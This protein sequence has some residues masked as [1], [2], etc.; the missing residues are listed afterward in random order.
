M[1]C[2]SDVKYVESKPLKRQVR[3]AYCGECGSIIGEQERYSDFDGDFE[4][5]QKEKKNYSNCPYCGEEL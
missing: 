5:V 2:Y 3:F 1:L 4:F